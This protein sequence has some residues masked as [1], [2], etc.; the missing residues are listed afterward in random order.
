MALRTFTFSSRIALVVAA[1]G[2]RLHGHVGEHLEQ[3]V[4]DDVADRSR[5][6]VE[7]AAALHPEALRH[8]DLHRLHEVAVPDR[9]EE[10][11]GE[12]EEDQVLYG[13]LSEVVVDAENGGFVEAGVEDAIQRAGRGEIA[14]EGFL[15][16]DA[17]SLGASEPYE[18]LHDLFEEGRRDGQ[19]VGGA[20]RRAQLAAQRLERPRVRVVPVHVAEEP[21]ELREGVPVEAAV[22]RHALPGPLPELLQAPTRLRDPDHRHVETPVP[23]QPLHRGE[24][25]LVGE[26]A[27]RSQ[28]N[29]RVRR[30]AGHFFS[31]WPPKAK[32]MAE[33]IL[34]AKSA[35]PREAKRW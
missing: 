23:D 35:S 3:V 2:G 15:H 31:R 12:A 33:R 26:I 16:D 14:P 6:L 19:V 21:Q 34:S 27:R 28:E 10:R 24:D 11:V 1:S 18:L 29:Q 8:G 17:S 9:L 4:P 7:G 22:L 13:V 25:L 5:L 20:A 32:R 30:D